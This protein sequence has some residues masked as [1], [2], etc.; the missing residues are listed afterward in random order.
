MPKRAAICVLGRS[1]GA[2]EV[3]YRP[4]P[5]HS[6]GKPINPGDGVIPGF[7]ARPKRRK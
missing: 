4:K 1:T 6:P 3:K 7:V 2:A 5:G